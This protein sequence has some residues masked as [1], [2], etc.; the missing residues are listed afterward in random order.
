MAVL[1]QSAPVAVPAT[2]KHFQESDLWASKTY[3]RG[4]HVANR[5]PAAVTVVLHQ[6]GYGEVQQTIL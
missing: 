1:Q 3:T 6:T 4:F 2:L 5:L